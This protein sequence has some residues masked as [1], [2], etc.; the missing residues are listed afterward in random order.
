MPDAVSC[1]STH[2]FT[3]CARSCIARAPAAPWFYRNFESGWY[4]AIP[5]AL[6][7]NTY[8]PQMWDINAPPPGDLGDPYN[9]AVA[10]NVLH[11][12]T[13]LAGALLYYCVLYIF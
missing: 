2:F 12:G 11:A 6:I 8:P 5:S 13:N 4:A 10:S 9:I 7:S 1:I 3:A